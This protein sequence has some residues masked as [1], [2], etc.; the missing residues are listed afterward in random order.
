[1]LVFLMPAEVSSNFKIPLLADCI[2]AEGSVDGR[3]G[4][5]RKF[6]SLLP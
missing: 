4:R 6:L 3:I 2:E 1:M 5:L